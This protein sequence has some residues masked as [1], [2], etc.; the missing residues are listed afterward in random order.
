MIDVNRTIED[1]ERLNEGFEWAVREADSIHKKIK[2]AFDRDNMDEVNFLRDKFLELENR[3][4]FNKK[5]Y[6]QILKKCK[7]YFFKKYGLDISNL[8]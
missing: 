1:L 7:G 8:F 3:H 4:E 6:N 2:L 5:I